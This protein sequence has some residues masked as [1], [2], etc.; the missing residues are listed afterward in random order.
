MVTDPTTI[1]YREAS[2]HFSE[3]FFIAPDGKKNLA[4][5]EDH[6]IGILARFEGI[7][8][9][10]QKIIFRQFFGMQYSA[11]GKFLLPILNLAVGHGMESQKF[12]SFFADARQL[13]IAEVEFPLALCAGL[14]KLLGIFLIFLSAMFDP[15]RMHFLCGKIETEETIEIADS[16]AQKL[17]APCNTVRRKMTTIAKRILNHSQRNRLSFVIEVHI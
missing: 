10:L 2:K 8:I 12:L 1:T 15:T 4:E 11:S 13:R 6:M 17:R 3:W 5:N 7:F 9:D 14:I 16:L